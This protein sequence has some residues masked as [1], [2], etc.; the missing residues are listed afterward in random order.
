MHCG[1]GTAGRNASGSRQTVMHM[2][3]QAVAAS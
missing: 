3:Q 2:Q 1:S